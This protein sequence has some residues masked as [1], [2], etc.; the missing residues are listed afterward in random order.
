[1]PAT[2][3]ISCRLGQEWLRW[4]LH[5]PWTP[6]LG[7]VIFSLK[8]THLCP[9]L[10]SVGLVSA[11]GMKGETNYDSR[12][13]PADTGPVLR[14]QP[15]AD[16]PP[17]LTGSRKG[18]SAQCRWAPRGSRPPGLRLSGVG[19]L[20]QL[21]TLEAPKN[22][23]IGSRRQKQLQPVGSAGLSSPRWVTGGR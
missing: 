22:L 18:P 9:A 4:A 23:L 15:K 3:V 8:G 1:M 14:M 10:L 5:Q 6:S 17:L 21:P 20:S 11:E 12:G 13:G 16:S 19:F 2:V 7:D